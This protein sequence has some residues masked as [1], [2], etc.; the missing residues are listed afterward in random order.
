MKE[1]NERVWGSAGC[2]FV[3]GT[4]I[5]TGFD[6]R[7]N[8]ENHFPSVGNGW[9]H[10]MRM[11]MASEH[12]DTST[13]LVLECKGA[14]VLGRREPILNGWR[15]EGT[16]RM[17]TSALKGQFNPKHL[18]QFTFIVRKK[19]SMNILS[20]FF[21]IFY[22]IAQKKLKVWNKMRKSKC[23]WLNTPFNIRH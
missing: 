8:A 11:V 21:H 20:L 6:S 16:I 5:T 13:G 14:G 1:L 19:S 12:A 3:Y 4:H 17:W 2:L 15:Q 18:F 7:V 22:C 23:L 9:A 10:V